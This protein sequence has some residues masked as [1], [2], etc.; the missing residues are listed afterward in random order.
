MLLEFEFSIPNVQ[1]IYIFVFQS[2]VFSSG[3]LE[4]LF[5]VGATCYSSEGW[6]WHID[7]LNDQENTHPSTTS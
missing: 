5:L 6:K 2:W 7:V 3:K 4:N 1:A